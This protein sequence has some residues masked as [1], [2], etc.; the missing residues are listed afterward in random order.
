MNYLE[1]RRIGSN[2]RMGIGRVWWRPDAAFWEFGIRERCSE[3]KHL[4]ITD[5]E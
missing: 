5:S 4:F 3:F 1:F 2:E